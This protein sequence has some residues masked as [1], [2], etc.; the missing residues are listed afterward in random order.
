MT[1]AHSLSE[2]LAELAPRYR[3]IAELGRGQ[4]GVVY[5]AAQLALSREVALKLP[6]ME[7]GDGAARFLR[8][9]RLLASLSHPNLVRVLDAGL[10]S[11]RPY[12]VLELVVGQPLSA[13]LRARGTL[14][15]PEAVGLVCQVAEGLAEA[16]RAGIVHRDVKPENILVTTAGVAKLADFG[17]ARPVEGDGGGLTMPGLLL[18]T[19]N[20]LA[21]EVV[22][23][24]APAPS[25]D[26]Y[27][28]GVVLFELLAGRPPFAG[29]SLREL[30]AK[31]VGEPPPRLARFADDVPEEVERT[32]CHL[33]A[34][35]PVGRPAGAIEAAQELRAALGLS[36][37]VSALALPALPPPEASSGGP[38]RP[39]TTRR[40]T[41]TRP[42]VPPPPAAAAR[43]RAPVWITSLALAA[44]LATL[45][46][47]PRATVPVPAEASPSAAPA[48]LWAALKPLPPDR[49]GRERWLAAVDGA[50]MV[51]V[52]AGPFPRGT[53]ER[54]KDAQPVR[55]LTLSGFYVDRFEVT[56]L[57]YDKFC[58]ATGHPPRGR[59]AGERAALDRDDCP[60]IEVTWQDA[61]DYAR[62]AGKRLPTEAEWEKAARGPRGLRFP[63]GD[64]IE[65]LPPHGNVADALS[66]TP[67]GYL[68]T[69]PVGKFPLGAS[70]YGAQDMAGNVWEWCADWYGEG[71]YATCP[72]TDP[73]GPDAGTLRVTRG[74]SFMTYLPLDVLCAKRRASPPTTREPDQGFRCARPEGQ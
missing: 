65:G 64:R 66:A 17:L 11:G 32:M 14:P 19:P 62:W 61:A 59:H 18:G 9:S 35:T 40:A 13:L 70:P 60:V 28:L 44:V 33:L 20:Y 50:E 23:G 71:Y 15:A 37:S 56:N 25:S 72:A 41:V 42:A 34:K 29:G 24:D 38:S 8:E 6:N 48:S 26:L 7:D 54:G 67:D 12:L 10:A 68:F 53:T 63:W 47:R 43:S 16:H 57:L 3:V 31:Q 46:W 51:R 52:P 21:P 2:T 58:R 39:R 1:A 5:R 4:M 27:A 73:P 22:L 69:A 45:A 36:A 49:D 30:L 74:G 55:T